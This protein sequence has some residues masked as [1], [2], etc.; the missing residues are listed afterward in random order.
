MTRR[1]AGWLVAL[2]LLIAPA[3]GVPAGPDKQGPGQQHGKSDKAGVKE[4]RKDKTADPVDV[5]HRHLR[6]ILRM[7]KN[8]KKENPKQCERIVEKVV[9]YGKRHRAQMKAI[10]RATRKLSHAQRKRLSRKAQNRYNAL[11][12]TYGEAVVELGENCHEALHRIEHVLDGLMKLEPSGKD[13]PDDCG[14]GHHEH[15]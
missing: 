11:F 6:A 13:H 1:L 7:V 3:G 5:I 4:K 15:E 14:C 10:R 2:S 12:S 8:G 9:A